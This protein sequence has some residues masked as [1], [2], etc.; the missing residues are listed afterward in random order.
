MQLVGRAVPSTPLERLH[1]L[2]LR[3]GPGTAPPYLQRSRDRIASATSEH[4]APVL[5]EKLS[6]RRRAFILKRLQLAIDRDVL[7]VRLGG[8]G[9]IGLDELI[10]DLANRDVVSLLLAPAPKRLQR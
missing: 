4:K 3:G 7:C 5:V 6:K 10:G 2:S 1:L 8:L 9:W